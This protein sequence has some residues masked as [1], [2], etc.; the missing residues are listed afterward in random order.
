LISRH[1]D[2]AYYVARKSTVGYQNTIPD[3][4]ETVAPL[5]HLKNRFAATN[6]KIRMATAISL[7]LT[8]LEYKVS[9]FVR[10]FAGVQGSILNIPA[11][12]LLGK[13]ICRIIWETT[14]AAAAAGSSR[15]R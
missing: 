6:R 3:A 13:H 15:P 1:A 2:V 5:N 8:A 11:R 9:V 12:Y 7:I 14:T 4:K 10:L